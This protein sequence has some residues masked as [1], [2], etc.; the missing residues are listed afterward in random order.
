[1]IIGDFDGLFE[2]HVTVDSNDHK[3]F[4]STIKSF[5]FKCKSI[6]IHLDNGESPVQMMTSSFHLKHSL[7]EIKER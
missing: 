1:M 5:P 7:Q 3:Q 6:I 2:I 4:E